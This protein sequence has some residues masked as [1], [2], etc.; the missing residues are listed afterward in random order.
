MYKIKHIP[1]GL[2]LVIRPIG[3]YRTALEP[4]PDRGLSSNRRPFSISTF[5]APLYGNSLILVATSAKSNFRYLDLFKSDWT[6]E[7]K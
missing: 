3:A 5:K 4:C 1:S 6:S 2:S 7:C